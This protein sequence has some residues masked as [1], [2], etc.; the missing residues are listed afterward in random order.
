VARSAYPARLTEYHPDKVAH[1]GKELREVAARKALEIKSGDA[2][3]PR[4]LQ[5]V[6]GHRMT[7][8]DHRFPNAVMINRQDDIQICRE[9]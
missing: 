8:L 9:K 7:R 6:W 2:V 5:K 3:R 4:A 1:I